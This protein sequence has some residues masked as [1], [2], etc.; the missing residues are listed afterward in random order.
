MI[1]EIREVYTWNMSAGFGV[2][3]FVWIILLYL[4]SSS[5]V[6]GFIERDPN[7][8]GSMI[9]LWG[10]TPSLHKLT[11]TTI[12]FYASLV[13]FTCTL[14]YGTAHAW[15]YSPVTETNDRVYYMVEGAT[16]NSTIKVKDDIAHARLDNDDSILLKFDEEKDVE[17]LS[18]RRNVQ[19]ENVY[20]IDPS[21]KRF[22]GNQDRNKNRI[23]TLHCEF[24]EIP[25][26][27][28]W[29]ETT[30]HP[31]EDSDMTKTKKTLVK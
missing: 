29:G 1:E 30:K 7:Q 6:L 4:V 15:Y 18:D 12:T 22:N 16:T 21:M 11:V 13:L 5:F 14:V 17:L 10:H 27:L 23:Q 28:G 2:P 8:V 9:V 31:P 3:W 26:D 20:C 24:D 25:E 19:L